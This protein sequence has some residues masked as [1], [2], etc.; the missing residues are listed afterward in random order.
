MS[1]RYSQFKMGSDG[2]QQGKVV[3]FNLE[4]GQPLVADAIRLLTN[5]LLTYRRQG[6]RG[7]VVIHGYG[8]SGSGGAIKNAVKQMLRET[9]MCGIVR[10]F[11]GGEEWSLKK[12]EFLGICHGLTKYEAGI[13]NNA[14]VTVVLLKK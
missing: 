1:W 14:G 11:V 6:Y 3:E 4:A 5:A 8:S 12:R 2:L 9:S 13:A 7:V 10:D